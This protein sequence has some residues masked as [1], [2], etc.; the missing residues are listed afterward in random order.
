MI[1]IA[2]R[3]KLLYETRFYVPPRG[4]ACQNHR[5]F[6]QWNQNDIVDSENI[7]FSA[8]NIEDMVDLLRTKLG[9][10]NCKENGMYLII[11]SL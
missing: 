7:P 4:V 10:L 11:N 9:S 8:T 6:E 1:A 5:E 3:Y 2:V